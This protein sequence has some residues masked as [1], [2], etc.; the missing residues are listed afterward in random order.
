MLCIFCRW[1]TGDNR[2]ATMTVFG[3]SLCT[4]HGRDLAD[5][6]A[7]GE[8]VRKMLAEVLG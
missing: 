8:S 2:L 1:T 6:V 5:R 4:F 3:N 7:A